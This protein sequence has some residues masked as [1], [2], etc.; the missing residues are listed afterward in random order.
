MTHDDHIRF[1]HHY[2]CP[3]GAS[4]SDR[5]SCITDDDCPDCGL[6]NSPAETIDIEG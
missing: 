5:S 1:E 3:C 6:S 4:W 2:D